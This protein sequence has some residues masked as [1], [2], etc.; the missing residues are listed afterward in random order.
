MQ[1]TLEFLKTFAVGLFYIGPILT[2]LLLL[3]CILGLSIGRRENWTRVD[4]LY[5]AFVTA[6]TVGYGD[7]RPI[8]T[9]SKYKSI[10]VAL[11]G[12]LLTGIIVAVGIH[13]LEAAFMEVYQDPPINP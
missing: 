8:Q 2:F 5:F 3:I 7:Y 10:L 12:L 9:S 4:A 6:T 13:S 1:F 11:I